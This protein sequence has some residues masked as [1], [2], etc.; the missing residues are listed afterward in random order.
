M[1][2]QQGN[3]KTLAREKVEWGLNMESES[4]GNIA[5]KCF[6]WTTKG[7]CKRCWDG[8]F[9]RTDDSG[10]ITGIKCRSCG[11]LVASPRAH[12]ED[13][14]MVEELSSNLLNLRFCKLP[15]YNDGPFAYKIFPQMDRLTGEEFK[16]RLR[17]ARGQGGSPGKLT[18][19]D[20][21]EGT[22][23]YFFLQAQVLIAGI[24]Q[25]IK[26]S[27]LSVLRFPDVELKPDGSAVA[28]FSRKEL[29][30]SL[31]QQEYEFIGRLGN[32]MSNSM[33]SAFACELAMKAI[34]LTCK[35]E[36]KK[37]H[38]L[39][40]LYDDL[41]QRCRERIEADYPDIRDVLQHG[42]KTFDSWRYF[43]HA[44]GEKGMRAMI[45][46]DRARSLAKSA[47]VILD[48]AQMMGLSG[49]VKIDGKQNVREQNGR[50]DYSI[51]LDVTVT[52]SEW[53]PIK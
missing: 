33:M 16:E 23:G 27:E 51:E 15:A 39:I 17:T 31:W 26:A 19:S 9:G 11:A 49:K 4:N 37:I 43:Q 21:P 38:D 50:R 6:R 53:P 36:A 1:T 29:R 32:T 24:R 30:K 12:E 48:E 8:L 28:H 18:R 35:N 2:E 7:R 20:F 47:R 10:A 34:S 25:P 3:A 46:S 22:P 45:D 14:R 52:G 13:Q 40:E 5:G 44:P 42:R 41:P